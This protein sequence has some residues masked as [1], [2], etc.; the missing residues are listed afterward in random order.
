MSTVVPMQQAIAESQQTIPRHL[1]QTTHLAAEGNEFIDARSQ[2]I[3]QR[4]LQ[5]LADNSHQIKQ[6]QAFQQLAQTGARAMQ[7]KAASAMMN[8]LSQQKAVSTPK[9]NNTGLPDNL[10]KG[11]ES[12]SGISLDDVKVHYNS[13]Q[14]AQL[15][16]HAY[17]QGSDIHVG[18]GQERHLPHEAW[19][20]VQQKQGRVKPTIQMKEGIHINDDRD[21][22]AEAD[23]MGEKAWS[24]GGNDAPDTQFKRDVLPLPTIQRIQEEVTKK[25]RNRE[26]DEESDE[27]LPSQ[28]F[29]QS[30]VQRHSEIAQLA[31]DVYAEPGTRIIVANPSAPDAGDIGTVIGPSTS[32]NRCMRVRFDNEQDAVYRVY[33][34]EIS[35]ISTPEQREKE[36]EPKLLNEMILNIIRTVQEAPEALAAVMD[37][38]KT[39]F[40]DIGEVLKIAPEQQLQACRVACANLSGEE[41]ATYLYT[42]YF[43][44]PLN[45]YLRNRLAPNM[46]G[47]IK[48]LISVTHALLMRAFKGTA[49]EKLTPIFRMEL[50]AE[51]IGEKDEGENLSFPAFTS[52]HPDLDGINGMWP[53]IASGAFG[54]ITQLALL[55]FEGGSK[56][57][58]PVTKYFPNENEMILPP[59]I[60]TRINSK[61]DIVWDEY[62]EGEF[63]KTW[64]VTVYHLAIL[65]GE[66]DEPSAPLQ[67]DAAGYVVLA[68]Q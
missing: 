3:V 55:V 45:R 26:S 51:W 1:D 37:A 56:L 57:L 4:R 40:T 52:T 65:T 49:G 12:L 2:A 13:P 63:V 54:P 15:N 50:Q 32:K 21:L 59:G 11:V 30:P 5:E 44:G 39:Q 35:I 19:H 61:Y 10:K 46:T 60:E 64:E 67:F 9:E 66:P 8:T 23:V 16:A 33:F 42:T 58:N 14:P 20:V 17:A 38:D 25:K 36:G 27:A 7:F 34:H 28:L 24:A 68:E 47:P 43:F 62:E 31:I 41:T 53:D 6:L 18:A 29:E 22:E 48:E